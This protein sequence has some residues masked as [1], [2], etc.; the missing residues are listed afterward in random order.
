MTKMEPTQG[1]VSTEIRGLS[2]ETLTRG[3]VQVSLDL[4][5]IDDALDGLDRRGSRRGLALD[6]HATR[7]KPGTAAVRELRVRVP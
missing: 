5:T 6:R 2:R 4:K 7:T 3:I 1:A